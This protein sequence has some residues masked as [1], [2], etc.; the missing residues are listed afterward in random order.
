MAISFWFNISNFAYCY[1]LNFFRT[2]ALLLCALKDLIVGYSKSSSVSVKCREEIF[3]RANLLSRIVSL[4]ILKCILKSG[5]R[6]T[7][8]W[9]E[10]CRPTERT[11]RHYILDFSR[12]NSSV[13]TDVLNMS[14]L[15]LDNFAKKKKNKVSSRVFKNCFL[16]HCLFKT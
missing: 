11:R 16:G 10:Q 7:G 15:L 4:G 13:Y 14:I 5:R 2:I 8:K 1:G 6:R 3:G 12:S 9:T